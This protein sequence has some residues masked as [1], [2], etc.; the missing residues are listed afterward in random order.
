MDKEKVELQRQDQEDINSLLPGGKPINKPTKDSPAYEDVIEDARLKFQKDFKAGRRNSYIM[1]GIVLL[2]AVAAVICIGMKEMA[3]KVIGWSIVGV[4]VIGMIVYYVLTHNNLPHKTKEY[5]ALVNEQ[6]N[7]R[8]FMDT[9]FSEVTVDEKEKIEL[10]DPSADAV[11]L[12][13]NN[14][15]SRNVI[16]GKFA[17]RSFKVADL[18][19][20]AGE[21]KSRSAAFVGKYVSF[22]NDLHF[23]G[24][25][26]INIKGE[27][28]IDLPTDIEDLVV[29]E[30]EDKFT[31]YGKKD[32][33][34][35]SDLSK[36]LI[37]NMK[38]IVIN[39]HLLNLNVVIWAGHSAVY[40]SCDDQIMTLPFQTPFVKDVNEQ[41][42]KTL[43]DLLEILNLVNE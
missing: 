8:N 31:L 30:N 29:L 3:F 12:G 10:A 19:L 43:V 1:M 23:E 37:E 20:Y 27:T 14:I 4:T 2:F 35:T 5:I 9:R 21:G 17:N 13:L 24:R 22:V 33:K 11:Y 40:L 7:T 41:Y 36:K 15:A 39:N 6:L 34:Y 18:G 16:S 42:A 38:K 26:I 25:Y 32:A 28:E